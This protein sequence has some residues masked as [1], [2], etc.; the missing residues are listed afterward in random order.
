MFTGS[1]RGEG[2]WFALPHRLSLVLAV[3]AA[4]RPSRGVQALSLRSEQGDREQSV[5]QPL[6]IPPVSEEAAR[7]LLSIRH[8]KVQYPQRGW[9][10]RQRGLVRAV[11][12]LHLDVQAGETVGIVGESGCGKSSL[13]RALA[14]LV[15]STSGSIRYAGRELIGLDKKSW[16]AVRRD[17]Q[18]VFQ[19]PLA[20]LNPKLTIRR[21]VAEPLQQLCPEL[22][23]AAREARVV[24]MIRRVGLDAD[25]LD[26]R[27][28][29][30]SGGQCQRIG[31]ARALV[32]RPKILICDEPVS[33]LDVSV[34]AQ[35]VNLLKE[36]QREFGLTMLFIAHD[37]AVVRHVAQRVLVMYL[38][39]VV[40]QGPAEIV[41]MQAKHPYTRLLLASVPGEGGAPV[42]EGEPPDPAN[43]PMGCPFHTRC[44]MMDSMC[45]RSLPH[46][47]RVGPEQYAA[48]H[49]VGG[50]S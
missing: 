42:I 13:A 18:M 11:Q 47:R 33:A 3:Q 34:Q 39:R 30:F 27:P 8:L 20:S 38:G 22:D 23:A 16:R 50:G 2:T 48:C 4:V 6:V 7:P 17:I 46:L 31:I 35:I 36:L 49:F 5:T 9:F 1:P 45:V 41:Y 19:D 32:V 15:T 25:C 44:P 29:E 10:W 14:G 12:D 24:D 40:E 28:H 43:P 26:K 21:I 37:L